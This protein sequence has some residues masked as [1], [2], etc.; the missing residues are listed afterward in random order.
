VID[1]CYFV[2]SNEV[3]NLFH[4]RGG[5]W[6]MRGRSNMNKILLIAR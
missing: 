4:L 6:K 2:I 1:L 3:A 5:R